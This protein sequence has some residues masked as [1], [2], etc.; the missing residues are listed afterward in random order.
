M[1][2]RKKD[3]DKI[4]EAKNSRPKTPYIKKEKKRKT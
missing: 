1:R 4:E 3:K 2:K